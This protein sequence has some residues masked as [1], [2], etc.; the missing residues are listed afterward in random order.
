MQV[1]TRTSHLDQKPWASVLISKRS[2]IRAPTEST[3]DKPQG[4]S[5][6]VLRDVSSSEPIL[7]P[8]PP[9][10][11]SCNGKDLE[12]LNNVEV[13]DEEDFS[14]ADTNKNEK[15]RSHNR[16][17]YEKFRCGFSLNA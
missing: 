1:N 17:R 9:R 11:S 4:P 12:K 10:L 16:G 6:D 14:Q 2:K 7:A 3:Q 15:F 13:K 8:P 5:A